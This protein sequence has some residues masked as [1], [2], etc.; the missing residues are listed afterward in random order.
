MDA[1]TMTQDAR[2]PARRVSRDFESTSTPVE[3]RLKNQKPKIPESVAIIG[4]G[5]TGLACARFLSARQIAIRVMDSRPNP[6]ELSALRQQLPN[7]PVHLGELNEDHVAG[8][9][10][11]VVSPGVSP[12]EHAIRRAREQGVPIL[13]ETEL[14]ARTV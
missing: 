4:L 10:A 8:V 13:G 14:F 5:R 12:D 1:Q 7:V 11:L 2:D 9:G 3:S 6:P